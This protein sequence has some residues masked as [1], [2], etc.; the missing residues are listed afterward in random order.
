MMK[1]FFKW[2]CAMLLLLSI[3]VT[4]VVLRECN[5]ALDYSLEK[6]YEIK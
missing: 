5:K 2:V 6:R 3:I 4:V 1:K